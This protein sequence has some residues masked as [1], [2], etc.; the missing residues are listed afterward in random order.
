MSTIQ[1]SIFRFTPHP[2]T[3]DQGPRNETFDLLQFENV[4]DELE[5]LSLKSLSTLSNIC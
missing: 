4:H 3:E 5:C 1:Q 2:P